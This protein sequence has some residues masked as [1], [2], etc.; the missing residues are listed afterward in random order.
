MNCCVNPLLV[1][2]FVNIFSYLVGCLF[3]LSVVSFAVQNLLINQNNCISEFFSHFPSHS[4]ISTS[5]FKKVKLKFAFDI[6]K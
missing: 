2:S 1:I 5:K 4:Y 3:V 6:V